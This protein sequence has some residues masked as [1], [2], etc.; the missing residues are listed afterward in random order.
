M[1][2]IKKR[3][4]LVYLHIFPVHRTVP[5]TPWLRSCNGFVDTEVP[6]PSATDRVVRI[7]RVISI[8]INK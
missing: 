4:L 5:R 3:N 8:K 7:G 1:N 6:G 2:L